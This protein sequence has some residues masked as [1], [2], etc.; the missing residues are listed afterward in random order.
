MALGTVA[1]AAGAAPAAAQRTLLD[2]A[3]V[4]G[5]ASRIAKLDGESHPRQ[6]TLASGRL[7][8]AIKVFD[9]HARPTAIGLQALGGA[10]SIVDLVA[11]QGHFTS[12]GPHPHN[13]PEPKGAVLEL[14]LSARSGVVFAVSL[15]AK[16]PV[17][18]SRLGKVTRLR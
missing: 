17:A 7:E 15:A 2:R 11:M 16:I 5:V 9:P 8:A 12:H 10:N 1:L 3:Q 13:T 14:I 4:L 18:L 6:I